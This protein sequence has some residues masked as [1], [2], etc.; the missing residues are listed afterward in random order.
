LAAFEILL[1]AR[2]TAVCDVYDTITS[3]RAYKEALNH[4]IACRESRINVG[5]QFD[6]LIADFFIKNEDAFA[7]LKDQ[8]NLHHD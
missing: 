4:D 7:R 8:T 6:P 2:V 3:K 5:T 1:I